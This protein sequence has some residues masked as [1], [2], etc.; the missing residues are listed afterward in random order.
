MISVPR[1]FMVLGS[2]QR[3]CA[4]WRGRRGLRDS[5]RQGFSWPDEPSL[6]GSLYRAETRHWY[7]WTATNSMKA[8][9][10]AGPKFCHCSDLAEEQI[11]V[12]RR[13]MFPCHC[14]SRTYGAP[15]PPCSRS[16]LSYAAGWRALAV[17]G[18]FTQCP[19]SVSVWGPPC[20]LRVTE[21]KALTVTNLRVPLKRSDGRAQWQNPCDT[22]HCKK[23]SSLLSLLVIRAVNRDRKV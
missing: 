8:R 13:F 19:L 12:P 6:L 22:K 3:S 20:P 1:F 18:H 16:G 23:T 4:A 7:R 2:G 14:K 5:V 21:C 10:L 9:P 17:I 11:A 15:W